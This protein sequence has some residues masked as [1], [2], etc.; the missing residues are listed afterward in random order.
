[1][2][3]TPQ[4]DVSGDRAAQASTARAAADAD[5]RGLTVEFISRDGAGRPTSADFDG[6]LIVK[7]V[8]VQRGDS[9]V[10]VLT[11]LDAQF[12]WARLRPHLGVNR[13]SLPDAEAAFAATGYERGTITPLGATTAWPV[14]LDS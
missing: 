5:A 3:T 9:F 4:P 10:F 8:V 2:T 12:S 1:M 13:L 14:V 7:S 11:P 6:T